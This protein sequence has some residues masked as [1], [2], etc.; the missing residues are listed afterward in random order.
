M[1]SSVV[2]PACGN[3]V[4]PLRAGHVAILDG[5]F[6]YFC[7]EACKRAF[8]VRSLDQLPSEVETAA[9]PRVAAGPPVPA[10]PPVAVAE[11]S[12]LPSPAPPAPDGLAAD[13]VASS[14]PGVA[15]A[16]DSS[17]NAEPSFVS[18]PSPPPSAPGLPKA[19]L[20]LRV[21]AHHAIHV[22]GI[23]AGFLAPAL[24]LLGPAAQP[25]RFALATFA[26]VACGARAVVVPR[27]PSD[28]HPVASVLSVFAVWGTAFYALKL[29][30]PRA[31]RLASVAGLAAAV[32]LTGAVLVDRAR[33][34]VRTA[35]SWIRQRLEVPVRVVRGAETL[36]LMP[37]LVKPGEE[38]V[39][40]VGDTLGVDVRLT[41][42][43]A[44]VT[45]WLDAP[46]EVKKRE[47]D[48][49]V[50]GAR[51]VAG[52]FRGV[53]TWS[54][55]DRAWMKL[56]SSARLRPD[57]V[58]PLV[59]RVRL[60]AERGAIVAAALVAVLGMAN[61]AG[62]IDAL[63]MAAVAA[64]CVAGSGA[65]GV[66]AL[67]QARG[68]ISALAYGIVYRDAASFDAAGQ[69]DVAVLCSRSTL[70]MGT[71]EI[72]ALE[73]LGSLRPD[74]VLA[75]AAGASAA[76]PHPSAGAVREAARAKGEPAE[77]VRHATH[78]PGLGVTA[79]TATGE[80]LVVGNRALLLREKVSIAVAD[81][82]VTA[83]EGEGRSV[84]LVAI[85]G[86]LV[87]LLALQDGLRPGARA[88]VQRLLD[89]HI[90][91][92]LLSGEARETCETIGRALDVEHIRPEVLPQDRG[93]EVRALDDGGHVVAVLGHPQDDDAALG[94]A[95]VSVALG[96]AGATPGEWAIALASDDV[97]DAARA[98]SIAVESRHRTKLA[99]ALGLA[100]GGVAA[101]GIALGLLPL[102]LGPL[103][104]LFGLVAAV[105][106]ARM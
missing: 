80:R 31:L 52:G 65:V 85:G 66:V 44:V 42:G 12:P 70:L 51:I 43:E 95:Q 98:L 75:L 2:C 55:A 78:H 60:T 33:E 48:P 35:R 3:P 73:S 101:V 18:A 16:A 9:P 11:P 6:R 20:P 58:G 41:A 94:A 83:L 79:L 30:D 39:V 64:F 105:V 103:L 84:T 22:G 74:R 54:G 19:V 15:P 68:S 97:R 4:D 46:T 37:D 63:A 69:V 24:G 40:R 89:A 92:V 90:E 57:V 1:S 38:V 72:V 29:G 10:R 88:A 99:I 56:V 49:V 71:P 47:G 81:G 104:S 76:S 50:A 21:Y 86:K 25:A 62:G 93:A 32:H 7:D 14:A 61:G 96:A 45:P 34:G 27:E 91:P 67:H 82:R 77:S 17:T 59:R 87:G 28:V 26:F 13:V 53:V 36:D 23:L 100:P 106:H 5:A 8:V 102:A